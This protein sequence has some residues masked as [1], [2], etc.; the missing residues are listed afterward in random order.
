M[1]RKDYIGN[2]ATCTCENDKYAGMQE[3]LLM[4]QSLHV[5]KLQKKKNSNK[6]YFTKYCSEKTV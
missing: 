6:K 1:C 3:V 4:I 2:P 5:I